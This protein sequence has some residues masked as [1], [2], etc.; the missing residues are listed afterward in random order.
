MYGWRKPEVKQ[1]CSESGLWE[2]F[3]VC[4]PAPELQIWQ[5][6]GNLDHPL[7]AWLQ[8]D[9][10]PF[11]QSGNCSFGLTFFSADWTALQCLT[12]ICQISFSYRTIQKYAGTRLFGTFLSARTGVHCSQESSKMLGCSIHDQRPW[13]YMVSKEPRVRRKLSTATRRNGLVEIL[14]SSISRS[15]HTRVCVADSAHIKWCTREKCRKLCQGETFRNVK[16]GR[17]AF[18]QFY[19]RTA[20]LRRFRCQRNIMSYTE[21]G[22]NEGIHLR[23]LTK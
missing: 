2:R 12:K 5:T 22:V 17:R 8:H 16:V 14:I 13:D 23:Y 15:R 7:L 4:R 1:H 20:L 18:Y 19:L 10:P 9:V 6:S 3:F 21:W 11:H